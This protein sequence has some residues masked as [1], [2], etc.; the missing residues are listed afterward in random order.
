MQ[1]PFFTKIQNWDNLEKHIFKYIFETPAPFKLE[2]DDGVVL[3]VTPSVLADETV[4][5]SFVK[6]P[7]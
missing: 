7:N 6:A 2:R 1:K 4:M 5:V 3:E